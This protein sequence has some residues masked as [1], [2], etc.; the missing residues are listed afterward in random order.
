MAQ[1]KN[2]NRGIFILRICFP[3][4]MLL[5]HGWPKVRTLLS[6]DP[7]R[8]ADPIGLGVTLSFILVA[9]AESVCMIPVMAGFFNRLFLIPP[10]INFTVATFLFHRSDPF[11]GKEKAFMFLLVF[12]ILFI[13]GK[14]PFNIQDRW[15][16]K[17]RPKNPI[18][19]FLSQ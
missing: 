5:E 2:V 7:I 19:N 16:K 9:F 12:I 6:G 17:K 18:L 13:I 3:L 11:T 14:G 15:F 10:I 8:F 4:L 1:N